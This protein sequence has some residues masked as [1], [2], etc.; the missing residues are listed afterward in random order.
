MSKVL[1]SSP[2]A[3]ERANKLRS[4]A[5]FVGPTEATGLALSNDE[6]NKSNIIQV[7]VVVGLGC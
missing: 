1:V 5:P 6:I 4:I 2:V 7:M 3:A